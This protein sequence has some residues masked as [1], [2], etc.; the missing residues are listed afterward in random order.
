LNTPAHLIVNVALLAGGTRRRQ[1]RWVAS[2]ALLPDL[3]MFS[4]FAYEFWVSQTPMR[5]IWDE[6]YFD[7][8]WQAFF[9]LFNSLPLLALGFLAAW[10]LRRAG[11]ALL[12]ASAACHALLDL[13]VHRE[14][15]H[16]HFWPVSDW[17]FMS[18]VSYWDPE[19]GG[20]LGSLLEL[21]AVAGASLVLWRRHQN[22]LLRGALLVLNGASLVGWLRFYAGRLF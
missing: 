3:G 14:D 8:A 5:V 9:D 13:P 7:P 21:L 11:W 20:A 15:G 17:R 1:L 2:G 12:F 4:F 19:H 10:C 6:R 22:G 18:P 16:R